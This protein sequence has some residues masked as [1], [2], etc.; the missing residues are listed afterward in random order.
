MSLRPT[1][2]VL[3]STVVLLVGCGGDGE[4][5]ANGDGAGAGDL[6]REVF[7]SIADPSC[8]SCH[9]LADAGTT[10]TIGPNLDE[11]QP[12]REKVA[13]A[14]RNGV[15]VM[16]SFQDRLTDEQIDAVAT[17]VADAAGG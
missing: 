5:G 9:T 16:P 12:S 3:A 8:G 15:G 10:G 4:N 6:G 1:F 17:Y 13:Q 11:L 14:V 2:A 7:T